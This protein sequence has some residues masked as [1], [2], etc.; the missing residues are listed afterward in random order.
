MPPSVG[1]GPEMGRTGSPCRRVRD[2]DLEDRHPRNRGTNQHL[3][4]E[5]HARG[6]QGETPDGLGV[7][8]AK[9][10]VVVA[11][12]GA[13]EQVRQPGQDRVPDVTVEPGHGAALD[14]PTQSGSYDQGPPQAQPLKK[15][16][17]MFEVVTAVGVAHDHVAPTRGLDAAPEGCT[18]AAGRDR[19]DPGAM[20]T[21]DR[22]AAIRAAVV[23][24][25]HLVASG[26]RGPCAGMRSLNAVGQR[27]AL[28]QARH[29][30]REL[31]RHP[32]PPSI[33]GVASRRRH[34]ERGPCSSLN[35][36]PVP[37]IACP[38]TCSRTTCAMKQA[39]SSGQFRIIAC[40][41][42]WEAIGRPHFR[43]RRVGMTDG[44]ELVSIPPCID[45]SSAAGSHGVSRYLAHTDARTPRAAWIQELGRIGRS[46]PHRGQSCPSPPCVGAQ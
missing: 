40:S 41:G 31:N 29:Q 20:A 5:F 42:V 32:M 30:D 7:K 43:P 18:V 28:I 26:A 24:H 38:R 35:S 46:S 27:L 16:N 11:Q 13:E 39:P 19:D 22:W 44:R 6:A 36:H 3:T 10:A 12:A 17:Q 8:P 14:G 15:W 9:A 23:C 25:Q 1:P 34:G 45:A 37:A 4:G 2:G 21:R 33:P